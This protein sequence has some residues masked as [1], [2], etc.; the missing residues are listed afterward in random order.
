M[1]NENTRVG[2]SRLVFGLEDVAWGWLQNVRFEQTAQKAEAQNGAGNVVAV[3]YYGVG[4]KSCSGSFYYISG[5]TGPVEAIGTSTGFTI[6]DGEGTY[7]IE[8]ITDQRSV[9][10]WRTIDFE[11]TYYPHLVNS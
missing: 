1:S 6:V 11:G 3:E 10:Q 7:Y 4:Q 8:R 9:G 2:D 5:Q